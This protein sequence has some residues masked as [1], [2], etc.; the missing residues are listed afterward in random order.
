MKTDY[1]MPFWAHLAEKDLFNVD[2][3]Q[4]I[5]TGLRTHPVKSRIV[6]TTDIIRNRAMSKD[7]RIAKPCPRGA[8]SFR[9][10]SGL[11]AAAL[12]GVFLCTGPMAA[13]AHAGDLTL[14]DVRVH[15]GKFWK[16]RIPENWT[17]QPAP[18]HCNMFGLIA[19]DP[20]K[21]VRKVMFYGAIGPLTMSYQQRNIDQREHKKNNLVYPQMYYPVIDPFNLKTVLELWEQFKASPI[22][23]QG[24]LPATPEMANLKVVD[25][26]DVQTPFT[27]QGMMTYVAR[28][29]FGGPGE[30]QAAQGLFATTMLQQTAFT[31]K[32]NMHTGMAFNTVGITAGV[33]E[34]SELQEELSDI[35]ASI[36]LESSYVEACVSQVQGTYSPMLY[37]GKNLSSM[38]KL[39]HN[40]WIQQQFK[41]DIMVQRTA[42]EIRGTGRLY[43]PLSF[44]VYIF[45]K[46]E[47]EA[48][49]QD[50]SGFTNPNLKPIS[51]VRHDL[52]VKPFKDGS[53]L[54]K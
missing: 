48:Y 41:Q 36:R 4:K 23:Q 18:G 52:W 31:N 53:A 42:D 29:V 14:G 19:W 16:L 2:L 3:M 54:K 1:S 26:R 5:E 33:D 30:N 6:Y 49:L 11:L 17:V 34:F 39:F 40:F 21:P 22:G 9:R 8:F 15:E 46:D 37:A 50:P 10:L 45:D 20:E 43:D 35:V 28:A 47:Y 32:P 7:Y 38:G 25:H 51:D 44:D 13:P 24:Y 12:L 27:P